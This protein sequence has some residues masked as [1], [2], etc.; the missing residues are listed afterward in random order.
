[1]N[2]KGVLTVNSQPAV[3]HVSWKYFK[4]IMTFWKIACINMNLKKIT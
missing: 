4:N 3:L 1:V 2:R